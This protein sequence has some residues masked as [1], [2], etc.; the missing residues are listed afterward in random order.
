VIH[1][2]AAPTS[3]LR[4]PAVSAR[5]G[6]SRSTILRLQAVGLF[7]PCHRIAQNA[8]AF[9]STDIDAWIDSRVTPD[10]MGRRFLEN[11][12]ANRRAR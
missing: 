9:L 3:L 7:P 1:K 8:V 2:N 5:V 4:F 10:E 6:L 11:E 12:R